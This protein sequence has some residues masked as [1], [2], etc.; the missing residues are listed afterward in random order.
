MRRVCTVGSLRSSPIDRLLESHCFNPARALE[1]GFPANPCASRVPVGILSKDLSDALTPVELVTFRA[2]QAGVGQE[3]LPVIEC[4]D[5]RPFRSLRHDRISR[6]NGLSNGGE[7]FSEFFIG[8]SVQSELRTQQ[9][10]NVAEKAAASLLCRPACP[11]PDVGNAHA[12]AHA[13]F[14]PGGP[15]HSGIVRPRPNA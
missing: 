11:K 3:M 2:Q 13:T 5:L 1:M 14:R 15:G 7:S 8:T 9:L 4:D 6:R 10:S 12:W